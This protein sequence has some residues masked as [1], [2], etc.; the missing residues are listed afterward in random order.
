MK[1][2]CIS[3]SS[4]FFIFRVVLATPSPLYFCI[5]FRIN[6]SISMKKPVKYKARCSDYLIYLMEVTIHEMGKKKKKK[7]PIISLGWNYRAHSL[8]GL[9]TS[10]LFSTK[11]KCIFYQ[12]Y[13]LLD[14]NKKWIILCS[15]DYPNP[16]HTLFHLTFRTASKEG[17]MMPLYLTDKDI[18]LRKVKKFAQGHT[19]LIWLQ[20][21][22][23]DHMAILPLG[24]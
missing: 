8:C 2:G 1:S 24:P 22:F 11:F 15:G 5:K 6:L 17:T 12:V 16:L 4:L 3:S 19:P 20:I 21:W 7:N 14:Y 10:T 13:K 9:H 23:I 18:W